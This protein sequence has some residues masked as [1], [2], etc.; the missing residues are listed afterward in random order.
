MNLIPSAAAPS[1]RLLRCLAGA[2]ATTMIVAQALAQGSAEL[3]A[4]GAEKGASKDGAVP[5]WTGDVPAAAAKPGQPRSDPHAG[6]KPLFV[7]EAGN[8]DQYADRLSA[9]Q[10]QLVKSTKGYRMDVYPSHRTCSL[11]ALVQERT[12]AAAGQARATEDGRLEKAKAAA[13]AF[14]QPRNGVEAMWNFKL[15]YFGEGFAWR[16][17]TV[18][19]PAGAQGIGEP[20]VSDE[21]V[22]FPMGNP[23]NEDLQGAKG[24]EV[25]FLSPFVA[26]AQFA[27]DVTL[28]HGSAVKASDVWLYFASQRRVRRAPTYTYDAPVINFENL[29]TVDAYTMFS[30]QLDRYD[31]KL[32]GKRQMV[33]PYNWTRINTPTTNPSAVVGPKFI[34]RDLARYETHRVWVVEATVKAGLRHTFP[35]RTFYLDEDS[36]NIVVEDLYDA[37]GKVQRVMESGPL[38]V[39]EIQACVSMAFASYDLPAGRVVVDRLVAGPKGI[40]WLA[41]REGRVKE[42][43][44]EPDDLRRFATR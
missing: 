4:A 14:P 12:K 26:P 22:L 8:V 40:D 24:M 36:W 13:V 35:K 20:L 43:M 25:Y 27:G 39:P 19:P 33:V 28:V 21:Y 9:G 2:A 23:K 3:T 1:V 5:A 44:F 31:F 15:R 10:V 38:P 41:A 37:Q 42:S 32:A 30:G 17:Y 6:E 18:L 11:P 7:I 16:Y 34:N 29:V